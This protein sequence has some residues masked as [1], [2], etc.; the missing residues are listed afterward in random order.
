MTHGPLLVVGAGNMGRAIVLGGISSG[1]LRP[2]L[3]GVVEPGATSR[4]RLVRESEA[5]GPVAVQQFEAM[6]GG[7][8]W[9][10]GAERDAPGGLMLCVKPQALASVAGELSGW[11]PLGERPVVSILAGVSTARLREA[12]GPRTRVVRAMPNLPMRIGR[13]CTAIADDPGA[14]PRAVALARRVL[15]AGG[16]MVISLDESMMDAFTALAGSGP[17]YLFYLGE[18]MLAAGERLGIPRDV[19]DRVVRAT[20]SGSAELLRGSPESPGELRRAVTSPGGT[21]AAALAV[22]DQLGVM[23][24]L[25]RGMLA[26]RDRGREL[27]DA[28]ARNPGG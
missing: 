4:E 24:A 21:T 20:L 1:V 9:L 19:C 26:A 14:D 17:A 25:E 5:L 3:V 18:A 16:Q 28:A 12:L 13:G 27:S 10:A 2:D 7:M 8:G 15:G 11:G 22:F 23:S 6:A